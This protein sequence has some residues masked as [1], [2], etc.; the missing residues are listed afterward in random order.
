MDVAVPP[1]SSSG[2]RNDKE[3][4]DDAGASTTN[5]GTDSSHAGNEVKAES[6]IENIIGRIIIK[7]TIGIII[8]VVVVRRKHMKKI[9]DLSSMDEPSIAF[10][11]K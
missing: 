6:I 11:W 2:D 10:L 9:F 8:V 4:D 3:D 7:S 1:L 5:T